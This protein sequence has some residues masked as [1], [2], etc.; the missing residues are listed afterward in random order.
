VSVQGKD[1]ASEK[2]HYGIDPK[3]GKLE[4]IKARSQDV[5]NI[6]AVTCI[7]RFPCP[8]LAYIGR[9]QLLKR[10]VGV[11][12]VFIDGLCEEA[13]IDK[14]KSNEAVPDWGLEVGIFAAFCL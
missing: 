3:A 13:I 8:S 5:F 12:E 6:P 11:I 10:L 14:V 2:P 4:L 1:A 7:G 9:P